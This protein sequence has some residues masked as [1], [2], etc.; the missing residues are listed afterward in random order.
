MA[1]VAHGPAKP[2]A[3]EEPTGSRADG[4]RMLAHEIAHAWNVPSREEATSR[5]LDEAFA[6]S[7]QALADE[8]L[9]SAGGRAVSNRRLDSF[10]AEW[11]EQG[12]ASTALIRQHLDPR[13]I[14]TRYASIEN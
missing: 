2:E 1:A 9:A 13:Q 12:A 4:M 10:W 3:V 7:F 11:I 5:F 8:V 6:T 14:A